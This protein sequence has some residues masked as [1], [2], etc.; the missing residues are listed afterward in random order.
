M[1]KRRPEDRF[2]RKMLPGRDTPS[3]WPK[4]AIQLPMFNERAVCQQLID[5]SCMIEWPASRFR[6]QV[7]DDSTDTK[8]RQYVDDKVCKCVC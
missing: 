6:V 2:V 4:V 5:C 8:T 1:L 3:A 7:L